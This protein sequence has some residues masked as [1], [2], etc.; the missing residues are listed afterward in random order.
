MFTDRGGGNIWTDRGWGFGKMWTH[1]VGRG[2]G[3]FYFIFWL[4]GGFMEFSLHGGGGRGEGGVS[5]ELN[6]P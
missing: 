5:E 1:G 4:H 2:L 6:P 3:N